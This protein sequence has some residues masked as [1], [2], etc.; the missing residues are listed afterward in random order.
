MF[1]SLVKAVDISKRFPGVQALD[2]VSA[3]FL[4]GEC[5]A[6]MG[7][8]GAGKST[9]GKI[10]SGLYQPDSGY[11]ELDGTKVHFH[12][13]LESQK[14][15]INIVHQELLFC[16]NLSVAEN[17][18]MTAF[19]TR[20][21]FVDQKQMHRQATAWLQE[22]GV[23]ISPNSLVGSLAIAQQQLVQIAGAIGSGAKVL[24]FD[25][26]TSSLGASEVE[27]LLDL[28]RV[29]KTRGVTCIY[30]SHR[31][32]EVFAICDRAT[33]LRDGKLV[34]TKLV[35]EIDRDTLISM[36]IGRELIFQRSA[37]L[38]NSINAEPLLQVDKLS[39]PGKFKDISF[40]LHKGEI[41]GIGGL[42]GAGRTEVVES[43]FGLNPASTGKLLLRNERVEITSPGQ[44][45]KHRFGLAPED[46][47]RFGLVLSMNCIQNITL[48]FI[49]RLSRALLIRFGLERETASRY[50]ARMRVKAPRLDSA[51]IGLSGGN[52]QKLVLAK[53]LAAECDVLLVDEP[54]RGVD[55][56]AKAEIHALMR[57]LAAEGKGILVVSSELPELISVSHRIIVMHEGKLIGEVLGPD[58]TE[59]NLMRLMA[60]FAAA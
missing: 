40:T 6:L 2:S 10:I 52:Q 9:L 22:I 48:P 58:A 34:G 51:S 32:D 47:K 38:S 54:T 29:L 44:A 53:W 13:P 45:L 35:S 36:M 23:D 46:R 7:E 8:N 11:I 60:G 1:G 5:H 55:V 19:P 28:I 37:E 3:E 16:E 42:V 56:G 31:I 15:G 14:L 49:G 27:R 4:P 30:V 50:F 21:I 26:P 25:E 43:I 33:V 20:G 18:A 24:I 57:E 59:E 39:L 12:S 17:L 41:L